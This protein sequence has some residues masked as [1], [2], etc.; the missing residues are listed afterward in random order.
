MNAPPP[1]A[2]RRPHAWLVAVLVA[3]GAAQAWTLDLAYQLDD[4]SMLWRPVELFTLATNWDD[5]GAPHFALRWTLWAL[6]ALLDAVLPTPRPSFAYHTVGWLLHLACTAG[7]WQ[8]TRRLVPA[9]TPPWIPAAA[10]LGFGTAGGVAQAHSWISAWG[11][12]LLALCATWSAVALLQARERDRSQRLASRLPLAGWTLL[13]LLS[14]E[15]ALVLPP[16]LAVLSLALPLP[17]LESDPR[18]RRRRLREGAAL[19]LALLPA[20]AARFLTLGTLEPRYS[21][22]RS[23][24]L[25]DGWN[26]LQSG[27]AGLGQALLPWNRDALVADVLAFAARAL[28]EVAAPRLGVGLWCGALLLGVAAAPRRWRPLFAVGLGALLFAWPAGAVYDGAPHNSIG[29]TLYAALAFASASGGLVLGSL[30]LRGPGGRAL[31][32]ILASAALLLHGDGLL[33]VARIE[34]LAHGER[35]TQTAA[36]E[37]AAAA[38]GRSGRVLLR[39]PPHDLGGVPQLGPLVAEHLR[40]EFSRGPQVSVLWATDDAELAALLA[41]AAPQPSRVTVLR[42]LPQTTAEAPLAQQRA[43]RGWRGSAPVLAVPSTEEL[44]RAG[45]WESLA[46]GGRLQFDPPLAPVGFA[47]LRLT[48]QSEG[49]VQL[50]LRDG[51]GGARPGPQLWIE[52]RGVGRPHSLGLPADLDLRLGPPLVA[53]EV[54]GGSVTEAALLSELPAIAWTERVWPP[55]VVLDPSRPPTPLEVVLPPDFQFPRQA[56]LTM[57]LGRRSEAVPVLGDAE[58]ESLGGDRWRFELRTLHLDPRSAPGDPT[59]PS[60]PWAAAVERLAAIVEGAGLTRSGRLEYTLTLHHA[61]GTV[62]AASSP[63]DCV[64][65][66]PEPP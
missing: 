58:L 23:P 46:D 49:T 52:P 31:A 4:Y 43:A 29:R 59:V 16:L 50:L 12:L 55:D 48:P 6:W 11:D 14:K 40:P 1:T 15:P 57:R 63:R 5:P 36:L 24:E 22:L 21:N 45:T 44:E 65:H 8:L 60:A 13:A 2:P 19:T 42:R 26:L 41:D 54:R 53:V 34:R 32:S 20:L 64:Y 27:A 18:G 33:Q 62:G 10:A 38:V 25:A 35:V 47:G 3:T 56:R 37:R 66:L 51:S 17:L 28:P 61:D 39:A 9:G 7:V 30:A